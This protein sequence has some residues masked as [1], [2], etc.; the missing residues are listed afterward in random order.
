MDENQNL[1]LLQLLPSPL[2]S[3]L[4]KAGQSK[5]YEDG[6]TIHSR[7]RTRP[8]LSIIM[9]GR[10]RFGLYTEAGTYIQNGLLSTGHC[11]GEATLFINKPRPYDADAINVTDILDIPKSTFDR[12]LKDHSELAQALLITLTARLYEGLEF[13][14]DLRTFPT[15]VAVAKQLLRLREGGGFTGDIVPV[16]QIDLAYTLG[17]SRVSVGKALKKLQDNGLIELRYAEIRLTDR[18]DL[19]AW[20]ASRGFSRF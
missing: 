1:P 11:F 2:V 6:Q 17:Q 12:L 9:S 18:A 15:D 7:G 14:D 13:A 20:I 4:K 5:R 8:S 19:L 3:A 16:R 10:V